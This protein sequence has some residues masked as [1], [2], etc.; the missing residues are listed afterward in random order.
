MRIHHIALRT[1]DLDRLKDFYARILGL[2][3]VIRQGDHAYW[4][5]CGGSI[6]MLERKDEREPPIPAG[7]MDLVAFAVDAAEL[8]RMRAR[9]EG[10]RVAIE[11]ETAFTIYFRDPDGRRVG[12]SH[13]PVERG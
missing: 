2:R 8:A 1:A 13:Y 9:L 7:S 5:D 6:L 12:L 3:I 4:L 10:E 11:A